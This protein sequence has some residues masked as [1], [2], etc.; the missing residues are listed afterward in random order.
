MRN[1]SLLIE[2]DDVRDMVV[3]FAWVLP[4]YIKEVV[5]V[6]VF[7]IWFIVSSNRI[8]QDSEYPLR[9]ELI[10]MKCISFKKTTK[11]YVKENNFNPH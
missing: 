6:S 9:T 2:E 8:H 1:L 10:S 4:G 7:P 3:E 11:C 5:V